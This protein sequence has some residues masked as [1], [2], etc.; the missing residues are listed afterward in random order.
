MQGKELY[1]RTLGIASPWAV[2]KFVLGPKAQVLKLRFCSS[3]YQAFYLS[4][5]SFDPGRGLSY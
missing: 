2:A 3:E 4:Q 5:T 1:R